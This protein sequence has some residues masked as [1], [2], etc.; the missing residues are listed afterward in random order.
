MSGSDISTQTRTGLRLRAKL[1]LAVSAF[2]AIALIP[3]GE[4]NAQEVDIAD[5]AGVNS[6]VDQA[7]DN[8]TTGSATTYT[9][10]LINDGPDAVT[11][12]LVTDTPVSGITCPA[13]NAVAISGSGVPAGSFT[14]AD[15]TGAGI[16]LDTLNN[17]QSAVLTFS[18]QVN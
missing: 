6:D 9:V 14:I 11:G 3:S 10:N 8:V 12:A 4:L 17:G 2:A 5:A 18:C 13:G 7:A 16:T 1:L 15:L